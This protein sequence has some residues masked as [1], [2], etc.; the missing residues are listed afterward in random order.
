MTEFE[1]KPPMD[2]AAAWEVIDHEDMYPAHDVEHARAVLD[3]AQR[4][5]AP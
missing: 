4:H 1:W 5:K 3:L 2:R